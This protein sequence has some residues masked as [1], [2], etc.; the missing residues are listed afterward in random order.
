MDIGRIVEDKVT[1]KKTEKKVS[2]ALQRIKKEILDCRSYDGDDKFGALWGEMD[3]HAEKYFVMK[4]TNSYQSFLKRK[5]QMGS[6][7]GFSPSYLPD[8][9]FD[10]Q[11]VLVDWAVRKGRAAIF[12]DCGL[13]KTPMQLVWAKN[14]VRKTNKPVLILTP[15]A[16]AS[17]TVREGSKFGIECQRATTFTKA[18]KIIVTNY[19]KLHHFTPSDF[20]GVVCDESSAI[21]S[22][23]GKRRAQ[24]TEFLR[25]ISYRLLCTATAAPN[26]Y[27]EL[28]TSSEALG[29]MGHIDMLN[30]F[31]RNDNNTTDLHGRA[32][33]GRFGGQHWRFK[34]HAEQAFWRW[35]CSWARSLRK[36]SDLGFNDNK[37]ALP[38]LDEREHV[39]KTRTLAP[40]ML[41]EV[42]ARNMQEEREERRRTINERCE[43]AAAVVTDT[44]RPA[45]VW[46]HLNDEGRLL[47]KLISDAREVAG[48]TPDEEKEEIYEAFTNGQL[49][50][51]VLKPKIGAWG[52]N[53]EF[54]SHV[55][56]FASH[57]YEQY[58]QAVRRCW[59][60]G[61]T[62][63]V[64]VDLIVTEGERG[65]KENLLRKSRAAN[66]MFSALVEHMGNELRF[67]RSSD[68]YKNKVRLPT[69]E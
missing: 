24:V 47:R 69:W 6:D 31:F 1:I 27:I 44:K 14:V 66:R 33:G 64:I 48:A 52:L 46:C 60:F 50:V 15:L 68:E 36:P 19:E 45:V 58:Y 63:P 40:G 10:F 26:D 54:C 32:Y 22:F 25:T 35:V 17:Q 11:K 16:V 23:D 8:F 53:W 28:G 5:I 21:K 39:V 67:D 62:R 65:I 57:S 18:T 3:W 13:G 61:Q 20:A 29:E 2:A 37:F 9:L 42:P 51:I 38:P 34:G 30:R 59:R 49:R 12:A 4:K 7:S 41:F 43:K 55:V 56:T